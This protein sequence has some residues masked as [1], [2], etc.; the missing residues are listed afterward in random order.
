M[1]RSRV[2]P[3]E[4]RIKVFQEKG[5]QCFYCEVDL[6]TL[7]SRNRTLDHLKHFHLGGKHS[8]DN[9]VPCCRRCNSM[10][11]MMTFDELRHHLKMR[12]DPQ[13]R[14]ERAKQNKLYWKRERQLRSEAA[15]KG[16]KNRRNKQLAA[17]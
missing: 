15:K 1:S 10:R 7:P 3:R 12:H 11:Q 13:Y 17:K 16:W 4:V 14:H 9:L 5:N 8:F 6:T 2:V